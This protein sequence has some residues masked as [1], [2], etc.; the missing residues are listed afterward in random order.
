MRWMPA[1]FVDWFWGAAERWFT[2]P[3]V[4]PWLNEMRR[5]LGMGPARSIVLTW[6]NSPRLVIGMFPEWFGPKAPDWPGQVRLTGFPLYDERGLAPMPGELQRFLDAG[7]APVAFTPGSAMV[8]GNKFFA[9]AVGACERAGLR[10]VLLTRHGE[11]VPGALPASVVHVPFAPFS[12]LLP[13]CAAIAHHGGI[14]TSSQALAAGCPQLVMPMA[15]D[16]PDNAERLERLGVAETLYPR[17][18]TA[19]NVARVLLRLTADPAV[20]SACQA[21]ARRF[22]G[23]DGLGETADLIESLV[24]I[25]ARV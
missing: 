23:A 5:D 6:M 4:T 21:V 15:H 16:Q 25:P 19:K 20:K 24:P 1:W 18:F 11:Q 8:H 2:D 12:Q 9:T 13:R 10:G 14:G 22:E 7:A 3:V 17:A